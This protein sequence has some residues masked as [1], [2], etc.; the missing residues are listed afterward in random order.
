MHKSCIHIQ[1]SIYLAPYEVRACCQRFFVDGEMKGDVSLVTLDEPRNIKYSEIIKAKE[2]LLKGVNNGTDDR[3]SGCFLLKE[4]EWKEIKDEKL[5]VLSIE[6]H[7]L[8]NMKCSYCSD[9]Y[10]GGVEPQYSLE[11][12]FK[13]LTSVGE[14]LHIAWG[15]GEPT[16]RKDFNNLFLSLNNK[17]HPKTQRVFT[18]ALKYSK[19]LQEALDNRVTSTTT[20]IDAGNEDTFRK[21]RKTRGLVKVLQNLESYSQNSPDLVTIKYIFTTDNFDSDNLSQFVKKV[22]EHKLIKC[23][24]LISAD[25]NYETLK[26]NIVF[27]II[28]LYFMLHSEGIYA[29]TFDD[30]IFHKVRAIGNNVYKY[31]DSLEEINDQDLIVKKAVVSYKKRNNSVVIWGTGEFS[32]YLLDTATENSLVVSGVVDGIEDKWGSTFMGFEVQSPEFLVN[33]KSDI[34]IASVN[35]YGEVFNKLISLNIS[36]DRIIPNFLL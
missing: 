29:V 30:H 33:S 34:I 22:K 21:V 23:N 2:E 27:S 6:N 32:K 9:V 25:F 7:S 26:D 1:K 14:D 18:N 15:G 10:Y 11:Y 20:S 8:C 35:F 3:C 28:S 36:K 4:E 5:N 17:F 31:I 19:A 13:E 24:Y 16:I 12:L